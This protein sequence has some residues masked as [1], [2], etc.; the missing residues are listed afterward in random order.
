MIFLVGRLI[1][2]KKRPR[3]FLGISESSGTRSWP[4]AAGLLGKVSRRLQDQDPRR[5]CLC[6]SLPERAAA[7]EG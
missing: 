3:L 6:A 1:C 4:T 5:Q 7:D 2:A